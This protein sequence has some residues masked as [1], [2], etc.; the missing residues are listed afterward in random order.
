[1]KLTK[2]QLQKKAT[3]LRKKQEKKAKRLANK[4]EK[5][6]Y[7]DFVKSIKERDDYTCQISGKSFKNSKPQA[8]PVCHIISKENYPELMLDPNNVLCLSFYHHKNSPLST[9]LDGFCFSLWFKDKFP[10][11]YRYLVKKLRE[12]ER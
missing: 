3:I 1:M 7:K 5:Q 2:R 11:R 12:H 6:K 9:H 4:L 8:L 10:D